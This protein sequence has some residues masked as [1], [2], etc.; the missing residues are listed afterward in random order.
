[1]VQIAGT[2]FCVTL[3]MLPI[4]IAAYFGI[5]GWKPFQDRILKNKQAGGYDNWNK[6]PL[7]NKVRMLIPVHIISIFVLLGWLFF[8]FF[9]P[10]IVFS[11][12]GSL[13]F[14][15]PFIGV[16]ISSTLLTRMVLKK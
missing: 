1:M 9:K 11:T 12:G 16:L 13:L 15:L 4:A 7:A 14:I 2:I 10:R 5:K 8:G 6:P 3:L